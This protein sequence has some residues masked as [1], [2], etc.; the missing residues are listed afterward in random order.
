MQVLSEIRWKPRISRIMGRQRYPPLILSGSST[1]PSRIAHRRPC[2]AKPPK[3][4]PHG[5]WG[6][7][8]SPIGTA[9]STLKFTPGL[10]ETLA[11]QWSR[12]TSKFFVVGAGMLGKQGQTTHLES[13]QKTEEVTSTS[14]PP[15]ISSTRAAAH[16]LQHLRVSLKDEPSLFE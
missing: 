13:I 9:S 15:H 14:Q 6:F 16:T 3:Q 4:P 7:Q 2:G 8:S 1:L 11:F 10:L 5:E 12:L